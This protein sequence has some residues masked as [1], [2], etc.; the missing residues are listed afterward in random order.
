MPTIVIYI[1]SSALLIIIIVLVAIKYVIKY[2]K[3]P[4]DSIQTTISEFVKNTN[5]HYIPIDSN[6]HLE[7]LIHSIN[8]MMRTIKKLEF[9]NKNRLKELEEDIKQKRIE[10]ENIKACLTRTDR[11]VAVGKLAAGVVHE[12]NNHLTGILTS[13]YFISDSVKKSKVL[14][15]EVKLIVEE[16]NKCKKIADELLNFAKENH[17]KKE[18]AD[19][20][21]LLEDVLLIIH[22]QA[23]QNNISVTKKLD[24]AVPLTRFDPNQMEQV[25]LNIMINAF[26]AM[27]DGGTLTVQTLLKN[28]KRQIEID[29]TD[30]GSGI[31]KESLEKVFEPFYST[32]CEE[33]GTGLG[34]TICKEV[35][36]EHDGSI[37]IKSFIDVG[38]TVSVTLPVIS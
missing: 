19:V 34:L 5:V 20:N 26:E 1:L 8:L 36:K 32:K 24:A 29:F 7:K 18:L 17:P 21:N 33:G 12:I 31:P 6:K 22:K 13:C 35:I 15:K 23:A 9:E 10:L 28:N 38:T 16:T 2:Y 3:K 37:E 4:I 25:F 27:P 11:L 14:E 30:T